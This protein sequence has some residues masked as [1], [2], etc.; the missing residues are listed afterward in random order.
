MFLSHGDLNGDSKPEVVVAIRPSKIAIFQTGADSRGNWN[1]TDLTIPSSYGT[2]KAPGIADF[3]LDGNPE[4]VF[5]TE[6]ARNPK[7]AIGMFVRSSPETDAWRL[8]P[9]SGVDGIKH[10]LV[11]PIDLD[12]DGDVDLI[13]CEEVKNLGVIWYENPTLSPSQ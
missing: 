5:S 1:R 2:A 3:N 6:N 12:A 13:T 8:Q 11:V 9:I 7:M 4:I 10:D